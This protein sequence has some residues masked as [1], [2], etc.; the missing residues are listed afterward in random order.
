[1]IRL[2]YSKKFLNQK[3]FKKKKKKLKKKKKK[4]KTQK[5]RLTESK[6]TPQPMNMP[7]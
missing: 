3:N 5:R 2:T 6:A 7:T 1:M 4:K